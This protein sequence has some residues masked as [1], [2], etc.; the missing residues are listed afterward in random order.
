MDLNRNGSHLLNFGGE[1]VIPVRPIVE[2]NM[3]YRFNIRYTHFPYK[4]TKDVCKDLNWGKK[5]YKP[6]PLISVFYYTALKYSNGIRPCPYQV[7]CISFFQ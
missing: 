1:L 2:V 7:C 4:F 5:D 6:D 3:Y